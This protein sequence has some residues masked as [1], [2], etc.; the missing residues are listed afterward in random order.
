LPHVLYPDIPLQ[1]FFV[2]PILEAA[3][4][5]PGYTD[6]A[7]DVWRVRTSSQTVA[8]RLSEYNSWHGPFWDGLRRLF[9]WR[10]VTP[11]RVTKRNR[12]LSHAGGLPVPNLLSHGHFKEPLRNRSLSYLIME[13]LPGQRCD[14]F[15]ELSE[16]GLESY[17]IHLARLHSHV[18]PQV[19]VLAGAQSCLPETFGA[20]VSETLTW[21]VHTYFQYDP[22]LTAL[23]PGMYRQALGLHPTRCVPVLVDLDPSQYLHNGTGELCALIDTDA[24]V[25]GPRELDFIALEYVLTAA[26]G[27]AFTRGY[28]TLL[29]LPN[30]HYVRTVYRYLYRLMEV[31]PGNFSPD[32]WLTYPGIF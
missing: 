32:E 17:G 26:Q 2:E 31:F 10:P 25:I 12:F 3:H 16:V 19:R 5:D 11:G 23:L 14:T 1:N 9:K 6:H 28:S 4:C 7:T 30:L 8:L 21:L 24:Y 20:K 13:W 27:A 15:A 18:L 22:G 29:P